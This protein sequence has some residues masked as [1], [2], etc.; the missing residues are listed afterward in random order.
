MNIML[1]AGLI[2]LLALL[3]ILANAQRSDTD[4]HDDTDWTAPGNGYSEFWKRK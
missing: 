2:A 1:I 4:W 3:L